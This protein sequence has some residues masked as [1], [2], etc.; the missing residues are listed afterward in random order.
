LGFIY[1]YNIK[2]DPKAIGCEDIGWIKF[3]Q[4]RVQYQVLEDEKFLGQL[5]DYQLLNDYFAPWN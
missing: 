5:G 4:D 2:T 1:K 3:A